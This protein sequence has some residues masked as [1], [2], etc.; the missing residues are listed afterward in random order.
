MPTYPDK[1]ALKGSG[2]AGL[3]VE[4]AVSKELETVLVAT[5]ALETFSLEELLLLAKS[6]SSRPLFSYTEVDTTVVE[7]VSAEDVVDAASTS[8]EVISSGIDVVSA[9]AL[10]VVKTVV[11]ALV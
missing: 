7:G 1:P 4:L 3:E 10:A 9:I 11:I 6:T 5:E 2:L 8:V